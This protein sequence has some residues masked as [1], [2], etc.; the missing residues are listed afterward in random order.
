M[1]V[2]KD[3]YKGRIRTALL[4]MVIEEAEQ[5]DEDILS[6]AS[7][8]AEDTINT[9]AGV[10]YDLASEFIK[11][12]GARNGMVLKW[13]KDLAVY[14]VMQRVDDDNVPQKVI[15]NYEDALN[16]LADVGKGKIILSLPKKQQTG[17]GAN[18]DPNTPTQGKGLRRIGYIPARTHDI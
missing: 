8:I 13:A 5:E 4:D 10:L 6:T 3:D 9:M 7:Q 2:I 11:V 18:G 15:K 16:D 14:E 1:Y 12:G 17:D